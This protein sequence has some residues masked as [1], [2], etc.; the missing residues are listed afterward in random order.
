MVE[1]G[2]K[3]RPG[4]AFLSIITS[5]EVFEILDKIKTQTCHKTF[6]AVLVQPN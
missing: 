1:I 2:Y 5:F 6:L 3:Y 4:F